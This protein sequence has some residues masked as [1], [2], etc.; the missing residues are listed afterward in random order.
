MNLESVLRH[1]ALAMRE[2]KKAHADDFNDPIARNLP[3]LLPSRFESA[4]KSRI[5]GASLVRNLSYNR[6]SVFLKITEYEVKIAIV[7][8]AYSR[9]SGS[10]EEGLQLDGADSAALRKAH[11][12]PDNLGERRHRGG[13]RDSINARR[14]I[15]R[16]DLDG[17]A[18]DSTSRLDVD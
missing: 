15:I 9:K 6:K 2:V 8:D 16:H 17:P 3:Q 5:R 10:Q 1:S 4:S 18:L 7:L 13:N 14:I 11:R 12:R